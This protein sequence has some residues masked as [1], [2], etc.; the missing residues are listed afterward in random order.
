MSTGETKELTPN[1]TF[2]VFFIG[3]IITAGIFYI[4]KS[5]IE[6]SRIKRQINLNATASNVDP[7]FDEF[8]RGLLL[9]IVLTVIFYLMVSMVA[10]SAN[11]KF[12]SVV[13]FVLMIFSVV[14]AIVYSRKDYTTS[15]NIATGIFLFS[16]FI[17]ALVFLMF[18]VSIGG[19]SS[20]GYGGRW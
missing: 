8:S 1:Q 3:V 2:V 18:W 15:Y 4:I 19:G 6:S 11:E 17:V 12:L 5:S 13:A 20:Y 7:S 10:F 16:A 9:L 14:L